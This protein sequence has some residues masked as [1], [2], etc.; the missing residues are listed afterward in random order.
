MNIKHLRTDIENNGVLIG[1]RQ[2]NIR[3]I[4]LVVF[5]SFVLGIIP[6]TYGLRLTP[7]STQNAVTVPGE[8]SLWKPVGER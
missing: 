3:M 1:Y 5:G 8:A 4:F 6:I 7:E 2:H